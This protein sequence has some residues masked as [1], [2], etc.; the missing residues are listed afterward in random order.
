LAAAAL[1]SAPGCQ[2]DSH[3]GSDALFGGLFGAGTGALI[4]SATGHAGAGAAI[5]AGVGTLAGAA[6]GSAQDQADARNR[7]LI[8]AQLGRRIGPGSVTTG[9]VLN[10]AQAHV[11]DDLIINHIRTHGMVAPPNTNELIALQQNGVSPRVVQ[12]MQEA[13]P[14]QV[15]VQ[16]GAPPPVVVEGYYDRPYYYPHRHYYW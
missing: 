8:E 1:L 4:G 2:S 13:P 6:V 16:Q 14:P 9:E 11:N 12:A 10:M 5:G 15:I 7:A 3:T